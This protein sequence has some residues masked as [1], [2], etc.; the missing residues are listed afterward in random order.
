MADAG[1]LTIGKVVKRLQPQYPD[2]TISKVRY[3]EDEGLVNPSR[4]PSGYRL[5]SQRDI[6]RLEQVLY[7]QKNHFMP[8]SVIKQQLEGGEADSFREVAAEPTDA[9]V[10]QPT[11]TAS[12]ESPA[13]GPTMSP[14]PSPEVPAAQPVPVGANL[15]GPL[16]SGFDAETLERLHPIDRMPEVAGVSATFVRQLSEVGVIELKRSPHG[17]DLVDGQD[18]P[19]IH[20]CDEL[21]HFGIGPKNLRQYVI[22]ANRESSMFEHALF[23]YTRRGGGV[24]VGRPA[25][26]Q[27]QADEALNQMLALTD[28]VRDF[29]LRQRIKGAGQQAQD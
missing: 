17:R 13:A 29:L 23:V 18:L 11:A 22:S 3:L 16:T 4:T 19:L 21:A 5:Y 26:A 25:E 8:L 1:Y 24:E 6:S 10:S 14:V 9:K 12:P 28:Q 20:A 7:L 27:R 2:L 15:P